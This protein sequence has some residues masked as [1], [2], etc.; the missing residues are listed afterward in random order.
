[1]IHD[2]YHFFEITSMATTRVITVRDIMSRLLN[3]SGGYDRHTEVF[4]LMGHTRCDWNETLKNLSNQVH[5]KDHPR[6][7]LFN[8]GV[9]PLSSNNWWLAQSA[10]ESQ[11]ANVLEAFG[12]QFVNWYCPCCGAKVFHDN[13]A[14]LLVIMPPG[15]H[16]VKGSVA[17]A[18][19]SS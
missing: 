15:N 7:S 9:Y 2:F 11:P 4:L 19:N 18:G 6:Y 12:R 13:M 8:K 1:M 3:K 14:R 16:R 17:N 5:F 10:R